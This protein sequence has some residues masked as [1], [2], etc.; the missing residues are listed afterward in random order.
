M[1]LKLRVTNLAD[2]DHFNPNVGN[3]AFADVPQDKKEIQ[4]EVKYNF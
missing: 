1:T 3:T 4:A 2:R